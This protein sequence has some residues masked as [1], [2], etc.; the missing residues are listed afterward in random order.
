MNKREFIWLVIRFVGVF[1]L[2]RAFRAVILIPALG[3]AMAML[4]PF[5]MDDPSSVLTSLILSATLVEQI[6]IVL[7]AAYLLFYGRFIFGIVNRTS[8]NCHEG[9]LRRED[10]VVI[11]VRFMGVWWL[12]LILKEVGGQLSAFASLMVL[13]S[14]TH[15]EEFLGILEGVSGAQLWTRA[16]NIVIFVIFAWYF[17]K[18]GKLIIR[19]LCRRWLGDKSSQ[20]VATSTVEQASEMN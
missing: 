9:S 19:L 1:W 12:W 4:L 7:F 6:A 17:L 13:R 18:K 8:E 11:M 5:Y 16:A 14:F 20:P 15:G 10:Y 3:V 2:I